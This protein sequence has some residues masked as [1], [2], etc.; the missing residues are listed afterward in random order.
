MCLAIRLS[1]PLFGHV[2]CIKENKTHTSA[3]LEAKQE[4]KV[5]IKAYRTDQFKMN[6]SVQYHMIKLKE[7]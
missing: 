2:P 7:E 4:G 5:T 3:Q 6:K 1:F